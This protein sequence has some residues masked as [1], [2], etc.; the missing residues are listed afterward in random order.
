MTRCCRCCCLSLSQHK[1]W[2]TQQSQ[3]PPHRRPHPSSSRGPPAPSR[4]RRPSPARRGEESHSSSQSSFKCLTQRQFFG[5]AP[6][7]LLKGS[8]EAKVMFFLSKPHAA[9]QRNTT[10]IDMN[11]RTVT[12]RDEQRAAFRC[13]SNIYTHILS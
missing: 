11:T 9:Q 5:H 13:C 7:S 10:A 8:D 1:R 2:Q 3:L 12:Y 6:L 4:A